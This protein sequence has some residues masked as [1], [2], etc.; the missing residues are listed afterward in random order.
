[1][2][3]NSNRL[4]IILN[5]A[6]FVLIISLLVPMGG[7]AQ[8]SDPTPTTD[9]AEGAVPTLVNEPTATPETL[10]LETLNQEQISPQQMPPFYRGIVPGTLT[11]TFYD[12]PHLF[13]KVTTKP[14]TQQLDFYLDCYGESFPF[15]GCQIIPDLNDGANWSVHW[16]GKFR[17]PAYG[18]Y[19]FSIPEHDDGVRVLLNDNLIVDSG[20]NYPSPDTLPAPQTLTLSAGEYDIK[21]DYEQRVQFIASLELRWDGPGFPDE[22]IP[23]Y[24]IPQNP[25]HSMSLYW[26]SIVGESGS[27]DFNRLYAFGCAEAQK[28]NGSIVV[29]LDFGDPKIYGGTYYTKLPGTE[30]WVKLEQIRKGVETYITGYWNCSD[31][32]PIG[33]EHLT[34]AVGTN[35]AGIAYS[36]TPYTKGHGE[37]WADM[38]NDLRHWLLNVKINDNN[39]IKYANYSSRVSVV[40]ATDIEK[41]GGADPQAATEWAKG[42]ASKT[43]WPYYNY[44]NCAD[45]KYI[46]PTL[47]VWDRDHYWYLSWGI[48]NAWPLPETYGSS[49]IENWQSLSKYSSTCSSCLPSSTPFNSKLYFVGSLTQEVACEQVEKNHDEEDRCDDGTDIPAVTGWKEFFASLYSD[50]DTRMEILSWSTDIAWEGYLDPYK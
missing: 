27:L 5:F 21:I 32:A 24:A 39:T 8:G 16:E 7:S 50:S 4:F 48:P 41:W 19:T 34:L 17:V 25:P 23:Y 3:R 28:R 45:C 14:W 9:S 47:N 49:H 42:Y 2:F 1:M 10:Q 26:N 36:L 29:V 33:S 46:S 37:A 31:S 38:V 12:Y 15:K 22:I 35:N 30:D 43:V 44:G 13:G 18:E 20:W 6:L 11:A 40:G